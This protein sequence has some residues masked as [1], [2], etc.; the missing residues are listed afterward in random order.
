VLDLLAA[1]GPAPEPDPALSFLGAC[2]AG[3]AR[4]VRALRI[5]DPGIAAEAIAREPDLLVDAAEQD[6]PA[7]VRLLAAAGFDVNTLRRAGPRNGALHEAAWNGSMAM[8]E[9]LL[10]LGA[11]P[12]LKDLSYQ[13]TPAGWAQTNGK[14]EVAAY[15]TGLEI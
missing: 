3:D 4:Q 6:R 11:D 2:M 8:A 13:S 14:D 10:E 9:L 7:A 1:A 15:L 12:T 5:A